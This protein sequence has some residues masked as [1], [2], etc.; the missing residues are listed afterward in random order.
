MKVINWHYI[1]IIKIA[2][3]INL[4]YTKEVLIKS[5]NDFLN[6]VN[7]KNYDELIINNKISINSRLKIDISS[8]YI[9]GNSDLS[10]IHFNEFVEFSNGH[11][12]EFNNVDFSG[13]VTINYSNVNILHTEFRGNISITRGDN[14][15][16]K[17][18]IKH[19]R[20]FL[21]GELERDFMEINNYDTVISHCSFEPSSDGWGSLLKYGG[22]VSKSYHLDMEES[23]F[24]GKFT[25]RALDVTFGL[26][27]I[28]TTNFI[29]CT[30]YKNSK[31]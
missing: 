26:I 23:E 17:L 5:E 13:N 16:G 27:N 25:S 18:N 28:K 20:F 3:L 14:N 4:V 12:L 7:H 9:K 2:I 6:A 29:N 22:G 8:L 1:L 11:F 19:S 24:N 15:G 31:G 21:Q 30:S 10:G